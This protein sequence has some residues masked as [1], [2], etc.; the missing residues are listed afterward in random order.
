MLVTEQLSDY[1][2]RLVNQKKAESNERMGP[3]VDRL[4]DLD[5]PDIG[6]SSV[7]I[8]LFGG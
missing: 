6:T 7:C 2:Q 8:G 5:G 1:K 3:L 4:H